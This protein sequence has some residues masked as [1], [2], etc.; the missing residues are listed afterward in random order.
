MVPAVGSE[1][2]SS[3][4]VPASLFGGESAMSTWVAAVSAGRGRVFSGCWRSRGGGDGRVAP[5][6]RAVL[7]SGP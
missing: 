4:S 3:E 2:T 6:C 7:R 1:S 5:V